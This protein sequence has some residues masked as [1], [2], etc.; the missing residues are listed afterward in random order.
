MDNYKEFFNYC[1]SGNLEK[2]KILYIVN[3]INVNAENNKVFKISCMYGKLNSLQWLYSL[4]GIDKATKNEAFCFASL[5]CKINILQWLYS[6]G[7]IDIVT[8][9][10]AFKNSCTFGY[11]EVGQW[12]Y[13]IDN[14]IDIHINDD[15]VFK[16][17]CT[18]AKIDTLKWL[19]SLTETY[20][21]INE[22]PLQYSIKSILMKKL[23]NP[24]KYVSDIINDD[25]CMFCLEQVEYMCKLECK[26]IYCCAC[27]KHY[28]E[29]EKIKCGYCQ[30]VIDETSDKHLIYKKLE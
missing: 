9:N 21:I 20:I 13:S 30:K 11:L 27:L 12:L 3:K 15:E 17:S 6:L 26:H 4:N 18:Y 22:N 7:E 29:L 2:A 10:T 24:E 8:K 23:V 25:D 14:T 16:W 19:C 1:V 28:L 5:Y